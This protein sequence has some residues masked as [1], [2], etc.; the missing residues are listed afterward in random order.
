MGLKMIE[1]IMTEEIGARADVANKGENER[2]ETEII[3][4]GREK[5]IKMYK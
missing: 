4:A 1:K 2:S 3:G 5:E